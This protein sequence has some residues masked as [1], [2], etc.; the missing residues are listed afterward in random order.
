MLN[1]R[2]STKSP[3]SQL[4]IAVFT[5]A[6][7]ELILHTRYRTNFILDLFSPILALAPIFLTAHFLTAGRE[8]AHLEQAIQLPDHFTFIMLGYIAFAAVGIGNP[9]MHLHRLRLV[10]EDAAGDRDT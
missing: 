5:I 9:I 3:L 4:T 7:N 6:R 10:S 2:W 1:L 8:S